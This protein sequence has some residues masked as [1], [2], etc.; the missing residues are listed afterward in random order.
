MVWLR[1]ATW[2]LPLSAA[3]AGCGDPDRATPTPSGGL[4]LYASASRCPIIESYSA[5]P[6]VTGVGEQMS[7]QAT[8]AQAENPAA[9][10]FLW[11]ASEGAFSDSQAAATDYSCTD[12]GF[13]KVTLV[14]SDGSCVDYAELPLECVAPRAP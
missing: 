7:L 11:F 13:Q 2:L 3:L 14:V 5:N 12:V 1:C 8:V 10:S 9:V 4:E 6:A